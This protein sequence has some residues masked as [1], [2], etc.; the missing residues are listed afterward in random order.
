MLACFSSA[1]DDVG[2][3]LPA[4]RRGE[5]AIAPRNAGI[6]GPDEIEEAGTGLLTGAAFRCVLG[7][8]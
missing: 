5:T 8:M 7:K 6:D 3:F 1:G 2:T 4:Q